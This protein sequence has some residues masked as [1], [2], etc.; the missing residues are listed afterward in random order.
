[1][2]KFVSIIYVSSAKNNDNEELIQEKLNS[3]AQNFHLANIQAI[4]SHVSSIFPIT[5]VT[6]KYL[7]KHENSN[8][9]FK[10]ISS[11]KNYFLKFIKNVIWSFFL[12]ISIIIKNNRKNINTIIYYD[13]LTTSIS[14][15]TLIAAIILKKKKV[16]ICTDLIKYFANSKSLFSRYYYKVLNKA[17]GFIMVT[18]NINR[19]LNPLNKPFIVMEGIVDIDTSLVAYGNKSNCVVFTG[20]MDLMNG[21]IELIKSFRHIQDLPFVLELYGSIKEN[22]KE[23][24]LNEISKIKNVFYR[25]VIDHTESRRIQSSAYLLVNPRLTNQEYTLYSFPIKLLEYIS[26]G[27]V[28]ISTLLPCLKKDYTKFIY[29]FSDESE[30]G[31]ASSLRNILK[32]DWQT[33]QNKANLAREFILE[34]KNSDYH[35]KKIL[36]LGLSL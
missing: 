35:A 12:S 23:I 5:N 9:Y 29:Q 15:G 27:T 8:V 25:G 11:S 22:A 4:A 31:F 3:P 19:I 14:Y 36:Y 30:I 10:Y 18:E 33:L 16:A 13:P 28:V 26:S 1:M 2:Y 20:T 7:Y 32:L 34:Y 17:D 24:I 6:K 21:T